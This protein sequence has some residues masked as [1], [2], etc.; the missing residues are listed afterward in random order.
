MTPVEE[1]TQTTR[2]PTGIRLAFLIA[3]PIVLLGGVIALFVATN[4]AGL[5][6]TP[7]APNETMQFSRTVLKPGTIALHVRNTSP[8]A[9][10]VAQININDAIWPY[11]ADRTT[12]PRLGSATITLDYPWAE[13]Q[14]YTITLFTSNSIPL[15]TTI[16]VATETIAPSGNTLWKFTLVGLYVGIIPVVLGMFWLPVLGNMGPR[17]MLFL[18]AATVGLLIFIGID[19]LSEAMEQAAALGSPFQGNGLIGIGIVGTWLLLDAIGKRTSGTELTG[20]S[21]HFALAWMIAIGIG[22]HNFG[23]GLAIG[24]A[25]TVGAATLGT[26]LVIGFI[27]QNI[28]EGFGILVPIAR[29]KPSLKTLAMLGLIGGGP[30]IL[31]AWA[32]G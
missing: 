6:V 28:T 14:A 29:D 23:E 17:S 12:I 32:G 11:R 7:A 25:Y 24:A 30:A 20:R 31:G 13:G 10:T 21:R 26:F 5:N 8:D 16:P 19:A 3:L 27:I 4:G 15:T 22:L 9:I 18:M 2:R 1:H